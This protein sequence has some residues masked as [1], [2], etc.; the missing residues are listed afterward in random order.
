MEQVLPVAV[1]VAVTTTVEV[2][3]AVLVTVTGAVVV[4]CAQRLSTAGAGVA[5]ARTASARTDATEKRANMVVS[6]RRVG[7]E[8][9]LRLLGREEEGCAG[10][11]LYGIGRDESGDFGHAREY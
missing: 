2:A 10:E 9:M 3:V 1:G 4:G 7:C 6:S 11:Y 8:G 5:A